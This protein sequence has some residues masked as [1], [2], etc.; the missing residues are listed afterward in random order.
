[1]P[2]RAQKVVVPLA[3]VMDYISSPLAFALFVSW[4]S[5]VCE[6][7][8]FLSI[9]CWVVVAVMSLTS[10]LNFVPSCRQAYRISL[11]YAG[12]RRLTVWTMLLF[13]MLSYVIV[14][15]NI[16]DLR[17]I[18]HAVIASIVNAMAMTTLCSMTRSTPRWSLHRHK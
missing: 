6:F 17:H 7:S 15:S 12:Q 14:A 1:M 8:G 11:G 5:R 16:V 18:W 9:F 13:A 2:T 3:Y 10:V 4:F